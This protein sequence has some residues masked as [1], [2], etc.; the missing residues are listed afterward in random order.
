MPG[1]N[2]ML[3]ASVSGAMLA[4]PTPEPASE[5]QAPAMPPTP[6]AAAAAPARVSRLRRVSAVRSGSSGR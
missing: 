6:I 4:G 1:M 3:D 5:A 2:G